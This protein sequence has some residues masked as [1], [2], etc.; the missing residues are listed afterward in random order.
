MTRSMKD[1]PPNML[2]N[3]CAAVILEFDKTTMRLAENIR[4]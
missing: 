3:T 1:S 2:D 4:F